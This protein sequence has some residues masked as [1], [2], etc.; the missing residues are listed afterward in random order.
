MDDYYF[1]MVYFS[2]ESIVTFFLVDSC[3]KYGF[4]SLNSDTH[5]NREKG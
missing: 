4:D 3:R 2:C 5:L 1:F